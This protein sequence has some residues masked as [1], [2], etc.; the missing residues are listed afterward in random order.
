MTPLPAQLWSSRLRVAFPFLLFALLYGHYL[1]GFAPSGGDIVNQYLPY[2]Q[3][4][5]DAIH[6]GSA[7]LWNSLTFCGRP[8]MGDIQV[9]VIYPPNW[10]HWF[11]P[12]PL[13]FALLL[14][15]HGFLMIAGCLWLGRHWRLSPAA[16][17]LGTVLF[18]ASPFFVM[19]YSQ[20]IVLFVYVGA[21]WPWMALAVSRLARRPNYKHMAILALVLALSLLAGAP[22]IT[23]YGWI[24]TL[25]L[26]LVLPMPGGPQS[27]VRRYAG[28]VVWVGMAFVFALGMTAIQT[29]Q[30]YFFISHSFERGSGA[31]FEY[32]T[33]GSLAPRLLWLLINPGFMGNG[34]IEGH[35]WGSKLHI[36]EA[37]FYTPLWVLTLL[38]PLGLVA[39]FSGRD[40][41]LACRTGIE[42]GTRRL[43]D[44]LAWLGVAGIGLG[45]LLALGSHSLLF[46]V[47]YEFVPGFDR[48]RVP[49][50]LAVFF[51]AGSSLLAS[52]A[53]H[54]LIAIGAGRLRRSMV[55]ACLLVALALIWVPLS[56]KGTI[57]PM[58]SPEFWQSIAGRENFR[59]MLAGE[60]SAMALRV[61]LGVLAAAGAVWVLGSRRERWRQWAAWALPALAALELFS[62]NVSYRRDT[63]IPSYNET[64]YPQTRLVEILDQEH[65]GGRVL[66]LDDVNSWHVDQNQEEAFPNRLIMQGLPDA[67]GYDPVNARW[68]GEWMNQLSGR[69]SGENPGGFMHVTTIARPAWLT[70][71]GVDTVISYQD[72]RAVPGLELVG[73]VNFPEGPL[74]VWRNT[75]F[76]GLAFAAPLSN[77]TLKPGE[78]MAD[79]A[80]R[81]LN[82]EALPDDVIVT[83]DA[84]LEN[85]LT[86]ARMVDESFA[87]EP[88]EHENR[89]AHHE[90]VYRTDWPQT[91]L[92]GLS[93][94]AYPGWTATIDG[95]ETPISTLSGAFMAIGVPE[96]EHEVRFT[97]RPE[98]LAAG[99]SV[100]L[101]FIALLALGGLREFWKPRSGRIG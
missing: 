75:R 90:L 16:T 43:H 40:R 77:P 17:L 100:S 98:G 71:M 3:L 22:Q 92:M 93:M 53:A 88:V 80:R 6:Q 96:G 51:L 46:R 68:I 23:F 82:P 29:A 58:L 18:C 83:G 5:R 12:L 89:F 41:R 7:P 60:A 57:W 94:S 32:I 33:D 35:Y 13:S 55:L 49:A 64:L 54:R 67:R 66:W 11:L 91:A 26:G 78:V 70:L 10:L 9:G 63:W 73:R 45:L 28:R 56:F 44:R 39:L 76:R 95:E 1:V 19:K 42:G 8:L 84:M 24:A 27:A 99:Q 101:L 21:W 36:A 4:V 30:T 72:L 69:P 59:H 2:Q 14:A 74:L 38:L 65:R 15:F 20:G 25:V 79:S 97:Y 61:T 50:R 47:F 85:G 48:F 31:S 34:A 81:A 86:Y 52:L 62:L 87:I 37:C